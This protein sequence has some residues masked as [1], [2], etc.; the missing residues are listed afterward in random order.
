[1]LLAAVFSAF[2]LLTACGG[3]GGESPAVREI[4]GYECSLT[5][6]DGFSKAKRTHLFEE[7]DAAFGAALPGAA[8]SEIGAVNRLAGRRSV[9]LSPGVFRLLKKGKLFSELTDGTYDITD[10][11]LRKLWR[12]HR[13]EGSNP[14]REEIF[15]A[16]EKT[17]FTRLRL[18]KE[19]N[20]AYLGEEGMYLDTSSLVRGWAADIAIDCM[21]EM[22][23][24]GGA[25]RVDTVFRCSGDTLR[26]YRFPKE[27]ESP[28]PA[29][30]VRLSQGACVP[31]VPAQRDASL[32]EGE[33]RL[34]DTTTGEPL[35]SD[36]RLVLVTGPDAL[37]ADALAQ[38]VALYGVEEGMELIEQTPF[39]HAL[40]VDG[41][42]KA[43]L[44]QELM[45]RVTL[46]SKD[47]EEPVP[48]SGT[49]EE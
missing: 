48:W 24:S 32:G 3:E 27:E 38:I 26:R 11:S 6:R 5:G 12:R 33:R 40:V 17:D 45:E 28:L 30:E 1:M 7:L 9:E 29:G 43:Y 35:H 46:D 42:G 31:I 39:F 4:R 49:K 47:I 2:P 36:L 22:G 10:G 34:F 44:S 15:S 20:R 37:G 19:D 21:H 18:W 13:S 16:V 23:V 41:G 8:N 25:V 14:S